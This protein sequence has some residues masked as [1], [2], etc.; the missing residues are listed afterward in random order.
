MLD[1]NGWVGLGG[2]GLG[3]EGCAY[4]DGGYGNECCGEY[5][6][7]VSFRLSDK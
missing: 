5:A 3:C 4:E 2:L 1:E 6:Q 7:S